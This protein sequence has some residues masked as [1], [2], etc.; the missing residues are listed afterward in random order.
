MS[1]KVIFKFF[2]PD[3]L[4]EYVNYSEHTSWMITGYAIYMEKEHFRVSYDNHKKI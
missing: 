2:L 3:L 1:R 4:K